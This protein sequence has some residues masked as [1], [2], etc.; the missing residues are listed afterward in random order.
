MPRLPVMQ[1]GLLN[2]LD[3]RKMKLFK[4]INID[5]LK[6]GLNK[7]RDKIV[8]EIRIRIEH[9]KKIDPKRAAL[10]VQRVLK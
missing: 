5:K 8:N 3:G 6:Q 2:L 9:L 4:N 10:I 7:T 1:S